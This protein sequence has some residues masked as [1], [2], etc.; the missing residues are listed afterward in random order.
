M[1]FGLLVRAAGRVARAPA[2][3]AAGLLPL[4]GVRVFAVDLV[5]GFA[6][7]CVTALPLL[8]TALP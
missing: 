3:V 4:P 8:A 2:G 5:V 7:L 6:F 1:T